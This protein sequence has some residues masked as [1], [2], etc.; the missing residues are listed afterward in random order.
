MTTNHFNISMYEREKE[1][2][3]RWGDTSVSKVFALKI[4][5]PSLISR[6]HDKN[7]KDGS[8]L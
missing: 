8:Q 7:N 3:V 4:Q 5:E 2:F 6:T 1:L